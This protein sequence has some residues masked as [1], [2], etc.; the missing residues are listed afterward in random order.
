MENRRTASPWVDPEAIDALQMAAD[1]MVLATQSFRR[2]FQVRADVTPRPVTYHAY[3]PGLGGREGAAVL[4]HSSRAS[5]REAPSR[6]NPESYM[7]FVDRHS[8]DSNTDA[9]GPRVSFTRPNH[10]SSAVE[11][12]AIRTHPHPLSLSPVLP[13]PPL[14]NRV[15]TR[16][17]LSRIDTEQSSFGAHVGSNS[18]SGY[19]STT[20]TADWPV[21]TGSMSNSAV[22]LAPSAPFPLS[23]PD[24]QLPRHS[25]KA[26]SSYRDSSEASDRPRTWRPSSYQPPDP[27]QGYFQ[28]INLDQDDSSP[29]VHVGRQ[30]YGY[31]QSTDDAGAALIANNNN[32]HPRKPVPFPRTPTKPRSTRP[33][34]F[35]AVQEI[36]FV[37]MI[38][39]AQALMLAGLAQA[40]VPAEIISQSFPDSNFGTMAWYSA[41]YGLTSATFVLPSGR[42]GDLFGHKKIFIIGFLW[43]AIWS[44]AAGFAPAVQAAGLQG[45]V[46]FCFCRAMQGIGPALLVPNGQALLG[47]TYKPGTRKNTVLCLFGAAAP[48]GFVMGAVMAS[49]FAV[50]ASWPWAFWT[51]AAMSLALAAISVSVLPATESTT[52]QRKES[53]WVQLDGLGIVFGVCGLVLFNFAFN[54]APIVSWT[55]P[56]TYFI[57]IIGAM[58]IAAFV[59]HEC[60]TSTH[61][62]IPIS[63][64]KATT[65]FVLGCTAAGW[66]CFSIWI[67]YTFSFLQV[68]RGWSPLVASASFAH[69]P[70]S[71]LVASL[72]VGF[73]IARV[74]PHWIILISMCAFSTGSL[75]LATA[76]VYQSYWFNTFFGILIMPFGM[77]M[78]NPA[79]TILLSNS[80]SKEHQG[81]A[82]SLVVTTVNYSYDTPAPFIESVPCAFPTAAN[83]RRIKNI[84]SAWNSWHH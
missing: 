6:S 45:T 5:A 2:Q 82:A 37:S 68:L 75:L 27:R 18:T 63:A 34:G 65:N 26:P 28:A 35:S 10:D 40:L 1:A 72:L 36:L 52:R 66:A 78:S 33:A 38:C 22:T 56:Y 32:K 57:L 31:R 21:T 11:T 60:L 80:V 74:K 58:L 41:A 55:T 54:Q 83:L 30:T 69:A 29:V 25:Y 79:A 23:G 39:L 15:S 7:P 3:N 47:R 16:P 62:L 49:L 59:W 14:P 8:R 9:P 67:Y 53:L 71:G 84:I 64:M 61:P 19:S 46:Y 81:I 43:L 4:S 77:D 50:K 51:L 17:R 12:G 13:P 48:L 70:I 24:V 20:P 44:F 73:L 76:P 42:L